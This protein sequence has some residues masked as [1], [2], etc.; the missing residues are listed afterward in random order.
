MQ[1]L[2]ILISLLRGDKDTESVVGLE[3]CKALDWTLFGLL[4]L[5]GFVLTLVS[6]W[7]LRKEHALCVDIGF[8]FV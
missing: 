8:P 4:I 2:V 3:R 6:V 5:S 1:L 7:M